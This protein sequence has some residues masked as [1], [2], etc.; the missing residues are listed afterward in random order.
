MWNK[1]LFVILQ[2]KQKYYQI[3]YQIKTQN[4]MKKFI[5]RTIIAILFIVWML[6]VSAADGMLEGWRLALEIFLCIVPLV[7][8]AWLCKKGWLD[9]ID[10]E[11]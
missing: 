7:I 8:I 2:R 3:N 1:K 6:A 11:E 4:I 5:K 9:D 10:I